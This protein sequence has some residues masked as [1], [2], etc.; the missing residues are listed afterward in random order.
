MPA[1]PGRRVPH[2]AYG[3][4]FSFVARSCPETEEIM[5]WR[6][7]FNKACTVGNELRYI[8]EAVRKGEIKGDGPYTHR[9][10]EWLQERLGAPQALITT[11]GTSALEMSAILCGVGPGDEVIMPSFTFVST[12]N[13]F[14]LKGARPRFVDIR[15][16][17]LNL[18]PAHAAA[19]VNRHTKIICPVHYAGVG[20]DMDTIMALA[21]RHRLRVVEDAAQ[22]LLAR[23]R[24]KPLGSFGDLGCISFHET[25]NF[26]SGEGGALIVNNPRFMQR[27]E[28]IRE[29]GTN[30]SRFFRGEVDKYT[31]VDIGSSYLPSEIIAA[32]LY[33]QLEKADLIH[34]RRMRLWERYYRELAPL[35]AR[36][37]V[38]IPHI[39]EE[40]E[41]NGHI[42]YLILN[43]PVERNRL[44]AAFKDKG[45]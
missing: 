8:H 13:A 21:R 43:R 26:S 45:I 24:G 6:I 32:F 29:K 39:P 18:D 10:H 38:R 12:A 27:A 5:T 20:C 2:G 31:W 14:L 15:P 41:H 34:R 3:L 30:R 11:S 19:S 22:A 17:T 36:G 44:I 40:C 1:L 9:C 25:K 33:A 42:F 37:D 7:P 16:E 28:I 35:E 23:Y 4:Y